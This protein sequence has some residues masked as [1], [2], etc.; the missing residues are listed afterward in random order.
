MQATMPINGKISSSLLDLNAL[1]VVHRWLPNAEAIRPSPEVLLEKQHA[2]AEVMYQWHAV[3]DYILHTVF[4]SQKQLNAWGKYEAVPLSFL[5]EWVFDP[6]LFPYAL[7]AGTNHYILW[8]VNKTYSDDFD[9]D[10]IN[11]R[12]KNALQS[13]IGHSNFEFAWYK[14]PKPTVP[15]FWHVQVF[16]R[17]L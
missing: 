6:S 10:D 2:M 13:Q 17:L 3:W 9:D 15:Q 5:K 16:W 14:N 8:N 7:P 4:G 11:G 1:N 12:I